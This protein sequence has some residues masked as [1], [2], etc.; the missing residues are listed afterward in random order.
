MHIGGEWVDLKDNGLPPFEPYVWHLG[1][2]GD[3]TL[4]WRLGNDQTG[5]AATT[6]LVVILE[7]R[8]S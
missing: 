8:S 3:T 5:S 6:D 2:I 1:G 7:P 4:A